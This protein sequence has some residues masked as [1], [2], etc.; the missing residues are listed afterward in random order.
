M[1]LSKANL[2]WV[3]NTQYILLDDVIPGE[4][5]LYLHQF[6]RLSW[7]FFPVLILTL[8]VSLEGLLKVVCLLEEEA[9]V[10][11]DLRGGDL[12][13]QD[14]VVH[15]LRRLERT[16]AFLEVSVQGPH[17]KIEVSFQGLQKLP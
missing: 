1:I 13:L 17:L 9:V 15:R 12:Q 5:H 7:Y 11:D 14:A 6:A 2:E 8:L 16:E 10:D 4:K 3:T